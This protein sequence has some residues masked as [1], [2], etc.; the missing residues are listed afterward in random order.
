MLSKWMEFY[1]FIKNIIKN[2]LY[3]FLGFRRFATWRYA[4]DS[5]TNFWWLSEW[6]KQ[7]LVQWLIWEGKNQSQWLSY[8]CY[9]LC[10][11]WM[12]GLQPSS[13]SLFKWTWDSF[14]FCI[15]SFFIAFSILILGNLEQL[16][17]WQILQWFATSSCKTL[18][19]A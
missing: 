13:K 16:R 5:S 14:T 19:K 6:P 11:S 9:F 7:R 8:R 15:V 4:S 1:I 2:N 18:M 3:V 10:F 12:D 17:L